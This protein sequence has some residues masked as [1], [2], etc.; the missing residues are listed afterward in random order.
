[1]KKSNV[2]LL[3]VIQILFVSISCLHNLVRCNFQVNNCSAL[4]LLLVSVEAKLFF[5]KKCVPPLSSFYQ[6]ISL[7]HIVLSV[8][9][10][11]IFRLH[12]ITK[13]LHVEKDFPLRKQQKLLLLVILMTGAD[14]VFLIREDLIQKFS[15]QVLGNYSK[16][17][18]FS[19]FQKCLN[20]WRFSI[21]HSVSCNY[22]KLGLYKPV[23]KTCFLL[24]TFT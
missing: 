9:S 6:G 4:L 22:K 13:C 21:Y 7:W 8:I 20:F 2:W 5:R 1:M 14:P 3:L 24:K 12:K 10:T 17:A 15:C 19:W 23:C 11:F 16:E 18:S